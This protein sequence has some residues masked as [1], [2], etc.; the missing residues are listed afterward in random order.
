MGL[1]CGVSELMNK[2]KQSS[3]QNESKPIAILGGAGLDTQ[4]ANS[5][6]GMIVGSIVNSS[7]F[8]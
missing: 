7:H 8:R 1:I 5:Y 6:F 2:T 3:E 4:S